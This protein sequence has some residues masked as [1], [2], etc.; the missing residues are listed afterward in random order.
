MEHAFFS[1]CIIQAL[2]DTHSHLHRTQTPTPETLGGRVEEMF[3]SP[4]SQKCFT[5]ENANSLIH[6]PCCFSDCWKDAFPCSLAA[7]VTANASHTW[8]FSKGRKNTY[9]AVFRIWDSFL[10]KLS[11]RKEEPA[12][13]LIWWDKTLSSDA[14]LTQLLMT[15]SVYYRLSV[16]PSDK[17]RK[18]EIAKQE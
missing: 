1:F 4:S 11:R 17:S 10:H 9:T 13:I 18:Q 12:C 8:E 5:R 14:T 16:C 2:Q 6:N 7:N 15:K 3:F